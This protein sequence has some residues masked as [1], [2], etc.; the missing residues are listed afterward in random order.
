M[1]TWPKEYEEVLRGFCR[2]AN[3]D[4][5]IDPDVPFVALGVDSLT[6]LSLIVE[7]ESALGTVL[8]PELLTAEALTSP[9]TLWQ[10]LC[11]QPAD[12]APAHEPETGR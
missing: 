8:P 2:F 6:M 1:S 9:G 12:T 7:S 3:P 5:Q 11:A 4:E 10:V